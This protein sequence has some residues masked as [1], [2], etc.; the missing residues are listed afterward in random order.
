[1][2]RLLPIAAFSLLSLTP[3]LSPGA[4]L[5]APKD[6]CE[7]YARDFADR[8]PRDQAAWKSHHDGALNDCLLQFSNGPVA[9]QEE[10]PQEAVTAKPA[11]KPVKAATAKARRKAA[12]VEQASAE[13]L[14]EPAVIVAPDIEPP[15]KPAQQAAKPTVVSKSKS[16]L[17]KIFKPKDGET[18]TGAGQ[19]TQ[20]AQASLKGK[21][22]P[23][24]SAWLDYCERKYASFNRDTGTYKSYKGV[25]RKCL[26]TD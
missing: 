7:A 10:A 5:A 25:E 4:A 9:A 24:S 13:P 6:Y 26:V 3:G 2:A 20:T 18:D 22:V 12:P 14:P 11:K 23:G 8:G 21:L 16:L 15:P 19:G 17:G 1:M